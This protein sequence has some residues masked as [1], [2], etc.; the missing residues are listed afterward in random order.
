MHHNLRSLRAAAQ[1]QYSRKFFKVIIKKKNEIVFI[2]SQYIKINLKKEDRKQEPEAQQGQG[3][4]LFQDPEERDL[5][6]ADI[7]TETLGI[8]VK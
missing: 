2:Q 4:V 3:L 8:K 7:L 1:T 6:A 5:G